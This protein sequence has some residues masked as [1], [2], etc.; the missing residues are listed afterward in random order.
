MS[1]PSAP[2]VRAVVLNWNGGTYVLDAVEALLRTRWPA[3]RFRVVV[4]DNA[5]TDG[6]DREI[7]RRFPVV[8]LRR[9]PTNGGFPANNLALGDL[10]GVDYVALVNN[11][12][13]VE[14][15]WLAPLVAAAEAEGDLGAVCPKLVFAPRFAALDVVCA[16]PSSPQVWVSGVEVAGVERW[17]YAWFGPGWHAQEADPSGGDERDGAASAERAQPRARRKLESQPARIGLP[18]IAPLE[19]PARCRVRLAADE[20]TVLTLREGAASRVASV[21][22]E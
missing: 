8:D 22:P 14:P 18:V 16:G 11:D 12:A 21:G 2:F 6:S 1:A 20:P 5:S 15:D 4:V 3:D 17:R 7:E 19:A 9:S 13:F 10:D